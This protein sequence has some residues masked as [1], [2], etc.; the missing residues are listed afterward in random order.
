[1][2]SANRL[3]MWP[4]LGDVLP[5]RVDGPNEGVHVPD[6][7]DPCQGPRRAR[8][9]VPP[10]EPTADGAPDDGAV[11]E[12][13]VGARQVDGRQVLGLASGETRVTSGERKSSHVRANNGASGGFLTMKVPVS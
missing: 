12:N 4:Y 2:T 5:A 8:D 6:P 13:A 1:M 9:L 10:G 7:G 11:V 3:C